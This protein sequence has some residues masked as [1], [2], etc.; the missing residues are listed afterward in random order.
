MDEMVRR[1]CFK[2]LSTVETDIFLPGCVFR[3]KAAALK[4]LFLDPLF[5]E[6]RH[7]S[8]NYNH[9]NARQGR[10]GSDL[11][12]LVCVCGEVYMVNWLGLYE[13][14]KKLADSHDVIIPTLL[15]ILL[16]FQ[17]CFVT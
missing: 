3:D 4:K 11:P 1:K 16:M 2:L 9:L 8:V 12:G 5:T 7:T 6:G 14:T 15:E 17:R 10:G 13:G